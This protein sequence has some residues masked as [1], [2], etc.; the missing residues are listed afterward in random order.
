MMIHLLPNFRCGFILILLLQLLKPC[1]VIGAELEAQSDG[2]IEIVDIQTPPFLEQSPKTLHWQKEIEKIGSHY[3]RLH[4]RNVQ[5]FDID[6]TILELRTRG[7]RLVRE[8]TGEELKTQRSFW[9]RVIPGDYVLISLFAPTAPIGSSL[10]ID[11]IAYQV[12]SGAPLSTYGKD[13]KEP[14]SNYSNDPTIEA[15]ERSV[16]RLYFIQNGESK[17]C[18]GFLIESGQ[19]LTNH[20]CVNTQEVCE[21]TVAVFGFQYGS[22]GLLNLGEQFDC[23]EMV[24]AKNS[25][26]L[27]YALLDIKGTPSTKWGTL[28]LSD[29]DPEIDL[30]LFIVQ[31]PGGLPKQISKINC[32][33]VAVPVDGRGEQTDF[34]HT[35]DTVG[36][37]SGSPVLN[38]SGQVVGLHH[39]GFGE[40]GE[41][42]ENRAIR[43]NRIIEHLSF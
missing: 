3:L 28:N 25:Y 34:S 6:N 14:I 16:A 37:S 15:V 35:C 2:I 1:W 5:G 41:W 43:M 42:E 33:A 19:L 7:G 11:Q 23:G 13:E 30:P 39:Y 29:G 22:N 8:Y 21:T 9:T 32:R 36:G 4:I 10:S 17:T 26:E 38:E 31:H 20:H 27:D 40:G 24:S 12:Y 18:T